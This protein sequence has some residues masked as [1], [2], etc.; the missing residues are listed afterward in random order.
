MNKIKTFF[1]SRGGKILLLL[2]LIL[3]FLIPAGMIREL[4]RERMLR[5]A[6][7]EREIMKAWGEEFTILGPVLRI[8]C[9]ERN[10]YKTVNEKKEAK[11]E[12]RETEFFLCITPQ[13]LFEDIDLETL[14]KKRG[15]FSVPL[16]S[17]TLHL[18]G[19]FSP[20]QLQSE[21]KSN[22]KAFVEKAE[23]VINLAAMNGIKGINKAEW[24]GKDMF[25][26]PGANG[27][28]MNSKNSRNP[29]AGIHSQAVFIKNIENTFDIEISIQGAKT[30][31][32]A[33]LGKNS[34]FNIKADWPAPSFRGSYLPAAHT[35]NENGFTANW[36]LNY[37]NQSVPLVWQD[38]TGQINF[39]YNDFE[40]NFFKAVDHYDM[41]TRAVKYAILFIIIPFLG[42]FI[43][44]LLFRNNIHPVQY[45]LAGIGNVVFYLLLLSISEHIVFSGAYII[46]AFAVVL[47]TCLYSRSF[48]GAW[49]KSLIMAGVMAFLYAFLYFTLQSEDWALLIGSIGAFCITALLMFLTRKLDWWGTA[50]S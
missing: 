29:S 9:L 27:F 40:V 28:S 47:M 42:F 36:E 18:K 49:G 7:V 43:F 22:Q 45:L 6:D 33:P 17:G 30:L 20:E 21:L 4:I 11:I 31:R 23:L 1:M 32:M 39:S 50:N 26:L 3:I 35:I 12:I 10:E 41:N 15:I 38:H 5:A 44:E 8:P 14:V 16:F 25:F 2:V 13:E 37:L 19:K 48:L 24:N 34:S 46:S